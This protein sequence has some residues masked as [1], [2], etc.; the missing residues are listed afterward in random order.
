M[1]SY[2]LDPPKEPE[3]EKETPEKDSNKEKVVKPKK[4]LT[5]QLCNKTFPHR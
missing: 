5:C 1:K 2:I 3:P 4:S